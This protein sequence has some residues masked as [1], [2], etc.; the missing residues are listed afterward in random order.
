MA[1]TIHLNTF[2]GGKIAKPVAHAK[3]GDVVLYTRVDGGI[4]R[5]GGTQTEADEIKNTAKVCNSPDNLKRLFITSEFILTEYHKGIAPK[6][7]NNYPL[8]K[9]ITS[10]NAARRAVY[11]AGGN[12]SDMPPEIP[13]LKSCGL[14]A[15]YTPWVYQNIEEIYFDWLILMAEPDTPLIK[16]ITRAALGGLEREAELDWFIAALFD[17]GRSPLKAKFPRLHT[18]CFAERLKDVLTARETI[19]LRNTDHYL[20]SALNVNLSGAEKIVNLFD[21]PVAGTVALYSPYGKSAAWKGEYSVKD[22]IYVFD[23]DVLKP[24]FEALEKDRPKDANPP[25]K[26]PPNHDTGGSDSSPPLKAAEIDEG[27]KQDI[28]SILKRYELLFKPL[29]FCEIPHGILTSKGV[30]PIIP[31]E[32]YAGGK[33]HIRDE[34]IYKDVQSAL[35]ALD[36]RGFETSSATLGALSNE[37]IGKNTYFPVLMLANARKKA[38]N[39]EVC[40]TW[41][42]FRAATEAALTAKYLELFPKAKDKGK[43]ARLFKN[44]A[45][46]CILVAQNDV[47]AL[48]M[49]ISFDGELTE[50]LIAAL[51]NLRFENREK[52]MLSHLG[53][54]GSG[55]INLVIYYNMEKALNQPSFAYHAIDKLLQNGAPL[56]LKSVFLGERGSGQFLTKDFTL[57][58]RFATLI[59]AGSRSGKG[60]L[61]L[62]ILAAAAGSGCPVF[63]ADFKPDMAKIFWD[64]ERETSFPMFSYDGVVGNQSA[65]FPSRS[66]ENTLN[67]RLLKHLEGIPLN[68]LLYLKFLHLMC[69]IAASRATGG[70]DKSERIVFIVDELQVAADAT[71][72]ILRHLKP[73]AKTAQKTDEERE[74][75]AAIDRLRNWII[76]I[77]SGITAFGNTNGGIANLNAFFIFQD[78]DRNRWNAYEERGA[79]DNPCS[80]PPKFGK[81]V[82]ILGGGTHMSPEGTLNLKPD[83]EREK[84]SKY[85]HF[86]WREGQSDFEVFKP[87]IVLNSISPD[88][89]SIQGLTNSDAE[90]LAKL[91]E[92]E[93]DGANLN[94]EMAFL[95]LCD[96]ITGGKTGEI[97]GKA[98]KYAEYY[99]TSR[100]I[101]GYYRDINEYMHD[102]SPRALFSCTDLANGAAA[103]F[104]EE[105]EPDEDSGQSEEFIDFGDDDNE[106]EFGDADS[107][108]GDGDYPENGGDSGDSRGPFN[109]G[110]SGGG[111]GNPGE[112][113]NGGFGGGFANPGGQSS[114]GFGGNPA[115]NP[116]EAPNS[117]ETSSRREPFNQPPPPPANFDLD[118][119]HPFDCQNAEAKELSAFEKTLLK[120]PFGANIYRDKLFDA[121]LSEIR[122][123]GV[124]RD[125]VTR[126]HLTGGK[127][128]VNQRLVNLDGIIPGGDNVRLADIISFRKLFKEYRK[129]SLLGLD[130]TAYTAAVMEFNLTSDGDIFGFSKTLQTMAVRSGRGETA[131]RRNDVAE[132]AD[133]P[134]ESLTR[135]AANR[136]KLGLM[137]A[138]RVCKSLKSAWRKSS[139]GEKI[140]CMSAARQAYDYAGQGLISKGEF[141][142]FKSALA[143][144]LGT[145]V[146]I[147]GLG[148][149]TAKNLVQMPFHMIVGRGES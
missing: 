34:G 6:A 109:S 92:T 58:T 94:P 128:Y 71:A 45:T 137:F 68:A 131:I 24:Y 133:S 127:M 18:I 26:Q 103:R 111:S 118:D 1:K 134:R 123:S 113:S 83:F 15:L 4:D 129:I 23:R 12:F 114:G 82:K 122:R 104:Y 86:A 55:V 49:R 54:S 149:W 108:S 50:K 62:N 14:K 2:I 73:I 90:K 31:N 7:V 125:F 84:V 61:T 32:E 97:L 37:E 81:I 3:S 144:A 80:L 41:E 93:G 147:A 74:L 57:N 20:L 105:N 85:R 47:D 25:P 65:I 116:G 110:T 64:C 100:G 67:G 95:G 115:S 16:P 60:V 138:P 140:W 146:G 8:G 63:Y 22:G 10:G 135:R 69:A 96:K 75:A 143:F 56:S 46:N 139:K 33:G 29:F 142:P 28:N 141:K 27:I 87:Y 11:S 38:P 101:M 35:K 52:V 132:S 42:D 76:S 44:A 77:K 5:F 89:E 53:G 119:A 30:L 66:V 13:R 117:R 107:W 99:L 98:V 51:F 130:E 136:A 91:L 126:V 36:S 106:A 59:A 121:I 120:T 72:Q 21:H 145:A 102:F 78:I 43:F 48:K 70:L 9:E 112:Q 39:G 40:A 17:L 88:S 148:L 19:A 124:R 79:A